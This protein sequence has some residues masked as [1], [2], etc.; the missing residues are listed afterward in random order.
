MNKKVTLTTEERNQIVLGLIAK[1]QSAFIE[2]VSSTMLK[3]KP[4]KLRQSIM[5]DRSDLAVSLKD[6]AEKFSIEK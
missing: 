4:V 6:I 3:I 2:K 5:K 1:E